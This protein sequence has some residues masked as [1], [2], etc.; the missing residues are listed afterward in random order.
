MGAAIER[1]LAHN[2]RLERPV[3]WQTGLALP[4]LGLALRG[5]GGAFEGVAI[6]AEGMELHIELDDVDRFDR[7]AAAT[8]AD[9]EDWLGHCRADDEALVEHAPRV[10]DEMLR[11]QWAVDGRLA[12]WFEGD[13]E[14]FLLEQAPRRLPDDKAAAARIADCA[15]AFLRFLHDSELLGGTAI[16]ELESFCELLREAAA[17]AVQDRR[18]WGPAKA[19]VAQMRAEGV[20]FADQA[21]LDAWLEDFNSRD[22]AERDRVLGSTI[23]FDLLRA[24]AGADVRLPKELD[25]A[26]LPR[27]G[28]SVAVGSAWFPPGEYVDALVRWPELGELWEGIPYEEYVQRFEATLRGW[29]GR[30]VHGRPVRLSIDAYE[31]WCAERAVDCNESRA[32][33]AADQMRAG[34][35]LAWPPGR[36]E[37]CWCESGRKYK[38][39]CGTVTAIALHPLDADV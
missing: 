22:Q 6:L 13:V 34:N 4:L 12:Y 1:A 18:R 20:E 19:M 33:Y 26:V 16:D 38:R 27:Q 35:A 30:G 8:I 39:C 11:F 3:R 37:P 21:A 14:E 5:D 32:A 2:R 29:R 36:N 17:D 31:H 23:D 15:S 9:F 7:L 25:A 24:S 10:A 28:G